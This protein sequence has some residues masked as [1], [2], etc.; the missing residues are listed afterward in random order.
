M[1]GRFDR[2]FELQGLQCKFQ[3]RKSKLWNPNLDLYENLFNLNDSES[4]YILLTPDVQ[5]LAASCCRFRSKLKQKVLDPKTRE[6]YGL[7]Y[8]W[9]K[10]FEEFELSME[11][12]D[13][14]LE[15]VDQRENVSIGKQEPI[16]ELS[17]N[18]KVGEFK[19]PMMLGK[20][21]LLIIQRTKSPVLLGVQLPARSA[22]LIYT[23]CTDTHWY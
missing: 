13:R 5:V 1:I 21:R 2:M 8:L 18:S 23:L 17:V 4:F 14:F 6:L 9:H 10:E 11:C 16:Q 3:F 22:C 7:P 19:W 15:N 20:H 12:F